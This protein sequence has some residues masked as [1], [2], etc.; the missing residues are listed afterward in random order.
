MLEGHIS[1]LEGTSVKITHCLVLLLFPAVLSAQRPL[2]EPFQVNLETQGSQLSSGVAA[3]A[4]GEFVVLW[5]SRS[6]DSLDAALYARRF[7]A[8]G[9]P[10]TGEILVSPDYLAH[11]NVGSAMMTDGS[12]VVV[13]SEQAPESDGVLRARWYAPDGALQDD[14]VIT[15]GN[16]LHLSVA[17]RGDGGIVV[18]WMAPSLPFVRA[19]AFGPDHAPRGSEVVVARRGSRPA[20]AVGPGGEFVVA[21]GGSI[22]GEPLDRFDDRYYVAF[23][24]FAP[25]GRPLD[26]AVTASEIT[27]ISPSSIRA[28]KDGEGNSLVI[29]SGNFGLLGEGIFVRRYAP[30]GARLGRTIL[31]PI[32]ATAVA[33]GPGGNL[34]LAWTEYGAVGLTDSQ[35]WVRRFAANGSPLGPAVRV[36]SD[37]PGTQYLTGAAFG[38][39]GGF[40]VTWDSDERDPDGLLFDVFARRFRRR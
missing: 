7:G 11:L 24:R 31:L 30:N 29:W 22:I 12:F 28:G 32:P 6:L 36:A 21:F 2:G 9:R 39:G 14:V 33:V 3:N 23:R 17:T 8:D 4:A 35:I 5:T 20:V 25:D 10:T 15:R 27:E 1:D 16:A 38:A 40:V 37:A 34:L 26:R 19:R 18:A 13:F